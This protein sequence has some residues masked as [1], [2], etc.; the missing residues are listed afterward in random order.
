ME[1]TMENT[2]EYA[3]EAVE[4]AQEYV[5]AKSKTSKGIGVALVTLAIGGAVYVIHKIKKNKAEKDV[6]DADDPAVA[7]AEEVESEPEDTKK[8]KKK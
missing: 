2:M 4:A 5:P 6:L 3:V 8:G 1:N 7:E